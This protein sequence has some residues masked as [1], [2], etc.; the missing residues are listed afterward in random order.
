MVGEWGRAVRLWSAG[1][2]LSR[3]YAPKAPSM[4][5]AVIVALMVAVTILRWFVD[6]A[7]QSAALLY[8]VP[9]ALSAVR[10]GRRG[11]AY[12]AGV[13]IAAFAILELVRSKGD[14]DLTGWV[15]PLLAMALMGG[16]VGHL[17]EA[18][19]RNDAARRFHLGEYEAAERARLADLETSDSIV[20]R[21]AAA[22]WML[23]VGRS[24][25]ALRALDDTVSDG[26]GQLGTRLPPPVTGPPVTGPLADEGA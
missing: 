26:I 8:V 21:V 17:S 20:Q 16:L 23:E 7:G 11:G 19:A 1:W 2:S 5:L 18:A 4:A 6:G 3:R 13:A 22:R 12:A 9:I 25:D 14:P 24:E 15:A 10:F